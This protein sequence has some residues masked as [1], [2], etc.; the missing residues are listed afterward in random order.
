MASMRHN[1]EIEEIILQAGEIAKSL[2]HEYVTLEHLALSIF[3]YP[4]FKQ[5]LSSTNFD[6]DGLVNELDQYLKL[7][8]DLSAQDVIAPRKTQALERVFNRA[9]TQ[10]LFQGSNRIK[11][12]DLLLSISIE[13]NSYA[14]YFMLKYGLDRNTIV[15]LY[16]KLNTEADK[17]TPE[18]N[19]GE[20][21]HSIL[22]EFCTNLN[23]VAKEGEIDPIIGREFELNE[24]SQILAKRNKA[25]VLLVGDPGVG[26]TMLA[27]GLAKNIVEGNVPEY[28]KDYTVY[29]LDIGTLLAGSKYRGEFEEKFQN[30]VKALQV[31]GKTI[32]FIDE[33]HQM[34]GA[35]SNSSSSVD[36]SNMIKPALS[37][38]KIKVIASTTWD[39]YT[40][41]FE[42]DRALMRR[43]QR[44]TVDEPSAADSK[45]ILKGIRKN[46]EK[47]HNAQITDEAINAAVDY[48]VRYQTDKKLPDKAIDLIDTACAKQ[49]INPENTDGFVLEKSHIVE[50]LSRATKIP[51][52]QIGQEAT[53]SLSTLDAS[54]K[55]N[56][57]G[58]E[59]AIQTVL[60]KIYISKSGLK[61]I[62]K[63]IGSFLFLG[64]TGTGKTEL[65]KLLSTNLTM[66]LVRFDMS[67]FQEKHSVAKLIGAPPG[68]VGYEDGNLGGGMLISALE[69]NP[70][71][72][73][74]FDEIE[75]AHPDVSNIL[76]Q[77]MDEGF[78]TSSNGKRADG[79]NSILIMTSNLGA[80]DNERNTI[81]FGDSLQKTGEDDKAVK[82][83][84]KP[85][86]RNRIDGICKFKHLDQF[87][88]KKI[89][90]KFISEINDLLSDRQI[91]LRLSEPAVD[92]LI[93]K[94]FDKKMGARPLSRTINDLI[95]VPI[96]KKILFENLSNGSIINVDLDNNQLTFSVINYNMCLPIEGTPTIDENGFIRLD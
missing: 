52:D 61:A 21:A 9:L 67:E 19:D 7:Q 15:E 58:Q 85:E 16:K 5:T 72:I 42:K 83:F 53:N 47:F 77:F 25:N 22:E 56:L 91:K 35:G 63:P 14:S 20:R 89:V 40:Q 88:M 86:F 92:F 32:L 11:V 41:S 68:Y 57:Y 46:F 71:S 59:E 79:R 3:Q 13:T 2:R 96:S 60:E 90:A 33:A 75:K 70:N 76:L 80:A 82:D 6:V 17:N 81:G 34:R 23:D 36:F 49:K 73:I 10:V 4:P 66:K 93:E 54:I 38:G 62:N 65:A 94:G 87:S 26:K 55:Q 18:T 44:L 50:A 29:N 31:K 12:V 24:M 39:E 43:F 48:S 45:L 84:F 27:E 74:L 30:V 28:L 64:P 8:T 69:Q 1:S 78:V 95:K 37:K 51:V